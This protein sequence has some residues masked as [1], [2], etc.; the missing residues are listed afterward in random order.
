MKNDRSYK[1]SAS[2]QRGL[3]AEKWASIVL[4]L[5]GHRILERRYKTPGGEIDLITE[6]LDHLVFVEVKAR[7]TLEKAAYALTS[8]QKSR[9]HAA[10]LYY[11]QS[12]PSTKRCRFDV[13]LVNPGSFPVHLKNVLWSE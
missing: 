12:H 13:L 10:A 8:R 4:R 3:Q 5:K 11:L 1:G 7:D 6:T 9:L 2:Y